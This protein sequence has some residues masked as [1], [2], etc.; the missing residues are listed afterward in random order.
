MSALLLLALLLGACTS[1]PVTTQT[2]A[3]AG[4]SLALPA[5]WSWEVVPHDDDN[6][7]AEHVVLTRGRTALTLT[8][9]HTWAPPRGDALGRRPRLRTDR[10]HHVP[11]RGVP[12]R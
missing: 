2:W 5:G 1:A 10:G 7:E 3:S 4:A 6:R 11:R 8:R 12:R 9:T